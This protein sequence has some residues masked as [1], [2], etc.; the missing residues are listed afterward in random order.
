VDAAARRRKAWSVLARLALVAATVWVCV[1]LVNL[2]V[3]ALA[4]SMTR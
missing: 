4:G 1:Q 2:L 3:T